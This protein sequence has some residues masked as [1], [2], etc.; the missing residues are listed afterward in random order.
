[1][2]SLALSSHQQFNTDVSKSQ[3]LTEQ[4]LLKILFIKFY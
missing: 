4:N 2:Y 1:M 3:S